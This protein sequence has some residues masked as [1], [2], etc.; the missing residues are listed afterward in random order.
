MNTHP[1]PLRRLPP[2]FWADLLGIAWRL[3]VA[4]GGFYGVVYLGEGLQLR[5]RGEYHTPSSWAISIFLTFLSFALLALLLAV[6]AQF[7][8]WPRRANRLTLAACVLY[9]LAAL[10]WCGVW[11]GYPDRPLRLLFVI[12][13]GLAGLLLPRLIEQLGRRL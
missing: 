5:F 4:F 12:G 10:G 6:A 13:C 1:H 8:H 11:A 7:R 2:R 9:L 3:L